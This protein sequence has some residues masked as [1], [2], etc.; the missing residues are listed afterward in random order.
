ME[1]MLDGAR[2]AA[3]LREESA[4]LLANLPA[5]RLCA[6]DAERALD[7]I[8][9][10]AY[11]TLRTA[12]NLSAYAALCTAPPPAR[13]FCLSGLAESFIHGAAAVC[14]RTEFCFSSCA[15]PLWAAGDAELFVLCL[16]NLVLNAALYGG[17]RPA[18]T[19]R[20]SARGGM[21]AASVCDN[22]DGL[23]RTG[24]RAAL[25]EPWSGGAPGE[26]LGL[27][28][29]IAHRYAV[30]YGGLLAAEER[31]GIGSRLLLCLPQ[32]APQ[33]AFVRPDYAADRT[34]ALYVQLAPVCDLPL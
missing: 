25:F 10:A 21:A 12:A 29:A 1:T 20:C 27:G 33:G 5:A 13:P 34:S 9:R 17:E 2:I 7:G 24:A 16:G 23:P 8:A 19:V 32:A 14:R 28:L 31:R 3:R 18:V 26:G 30:H 4:H 11:E 22:G 15:Q 6:G